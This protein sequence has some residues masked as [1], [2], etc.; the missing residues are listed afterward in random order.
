MPGNKRVTALPACYRW[1]RTTLLALVTEDE[2]ND[3]STG[4]SPAEGCKRTIPRWGRVGPPVVV[5]AVASLVAACGGASSS[6]GVASLGSS[7]TSS[8]GSSAQSSTRQSGVLYASCMRA[9]GVSN[10]PDS[11][12]S[13]SNGEAEFDLPQGIKSEPQFAS[14][15]RACQRDLPGASSMPAKHVDIE[16]ELDFAHCMR[17]H[18]ISDFPDP[19]PGGGFD[20]PGDT[21]SPQFETAANACQSTGIH[22]NGP[23]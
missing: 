19:M 8:N 1:C 17:S 3:M 6:P 4:R 9:H 12:V 2:E 7:T 16:E 21:N 18:G 22:W 15:S 14:A 10:F 20:I 11:A 23:P 13:E 5:L